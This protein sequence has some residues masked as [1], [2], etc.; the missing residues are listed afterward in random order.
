MGRG[1]SLSQT[2]GESLSQTDRR[3]PPVQEKKHREKKQPI[4]KG[5]KKKQTT[6][7]SISISLRRL[8]IPRDA[9][10]NDSKWVLRMKRNP[11]RGT[12]RDK[13]RLG[14]RGF[15]QVKGKD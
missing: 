7:S 6:V 8:K 15:P 14:I 12:I 10:P 9:H 1:E 5:Q 4:G 11:D 3:V 2:A 13:V